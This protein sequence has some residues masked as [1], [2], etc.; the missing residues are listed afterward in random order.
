VSEVAARER[1]ASEP[2][3]GA[4]TVTKLRPPAVRGRVVAREQ[5]LDRLR[6]G[7]DGKVTL[8]DAPAGWG[9]TTLLVEWVARGQ[10]GR[11]S[12][13]LSLDGA[14]NDPVRFWT[15]LIEALRTEVADLGAAASSALGAPGTTIVEHVLPALINDLAARSE[16]VLLVLDDYHLITNGV[17]HEAMAWLVERLPPPLHLVIATRSDPPLPLARLRVRRELSELRAEELRFTEDE[18]RAFLVDVL[19]LRLRP[20]DVARIVE[21]TEGWAA[22]VYLAALSL[23]GH[24]DAAAFI[25]GFAGDDR[26]VVDFLGAEVLD[27]QPEDVRDFLLRTSVLERLSGPLCDAVAPRVDSAALLEEIERSNLFLVPL[28]STRRWYRYHHLFRQ[29]LQ[30]EL[31]RTLPGEV[32]ELHRR[33]SAWHRRRGSISAAIRHAV[34]GGDVARASELITDHW[35]GYLQRGRIETVAGWIESL[36]DDVVARDA[37]LCLTRAWLGINTGRLDEIDRWI[38]AAER[39]LAEAPTGEERAMVEQGAASL[40][41]IHRYMAG[42][43]GAA[44]EAGRRAL[45][46]ERGGHTSP[47]HPVGC[48]VLGVALF[49]S[50]RSDQARA[51]LEQAVEEARIGANNLSE[52]HALGGL[53]AIAEERAEHAAAEELAASASLLAEAHGLADHWASS[54]ALVV[55][56]RSL[57]R[58][59]EPTAALEEVQRAVTLS[60]RGIAGAEIAYARLALA[61]LGRD[62]GDHE[63]AHEALAA[64]RRG[65]GRCPDPGILTTMV[66]RTAR[67]LAQSGRR[68]PT[69][70]AGISDELSERELSVL[71]LL[72]GDMSQRE[73][74][75]ALYVSHNTVKTHVRAIFRKLGASSRAEA[76]EHARG[77]GL[78]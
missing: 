3:A 30:N 66:E 47:W 26:H 23:R 75:D 45:V 42:D 22:G 14:D 70:P 63:L 76:V 33:A 31:R 68:D 24:D 34:E 46:L 41:A 57:A 54:L 49:W 2:R 53:S 48:P 20:E 21:R 55:R 28:D 40:R 1:A 52:I 32:P 51:E 62:Q 7:S 60:Q 74:A 72:P 67:R 25:E 50:G 56:A 44:V 59:G 11:R 77:Q 36:G 9:K 35:Y 16:R 39:A 65:V 27:G 43:M 4:L 15:Y 29:L 19:G 38:D 17:I 37:R 8:V 18:A 12:A 71:L 61:R 78:L 5:L 58:R 73:I 69:V 13:W 6:L 10:E 64:A